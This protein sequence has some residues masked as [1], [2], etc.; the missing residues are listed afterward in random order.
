MPG[1]LLIHRRIPL[2]PEEFM[3][4]KAWAVPASQ[5]FPGGV[6]FSFAYFRRRDGKL[7]RVLGWDNAHGKGP[8]EHF[9][10]RERAVA[11]ADLDVLTVRFARRVAVVREGLP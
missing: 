2:G 10:G 7:A 11:P 5:A 9:R 4:Q 8:H 6:K 3:T 1:R